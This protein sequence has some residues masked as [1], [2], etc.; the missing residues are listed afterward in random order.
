MELIY[1]LLQRRLVWGGFILKT[2]KR[3]GGTTSYPRG[4][5]DQLS[6]ARNTYIYLEIGEGIT[7]VSGS[8]GS[9]IDQVTFGVTPNPANSD[10]SPTFYSV[11]GFNGGGFDA[12]PP[13]SLNGPCYLLGIRG[14]TS[15][16]FGETKPAYI[17]A[18]QFNWQCVGKPTHF[19]Y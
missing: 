2:F 11:G 3:G 15:T 12:T 16:E 8:Y 5:T 19:V 17:K 13:P 6:H 7:E 10:A 9:V 1:L 14:Q 4:F 18:V